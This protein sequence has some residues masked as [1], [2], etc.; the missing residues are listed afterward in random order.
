M[1]ARLLSPGERN[2]VYPVFQNT[3]PYNRV[4]I[5]DFYLPGNQ[6]VAVTVA[7]NPMPN[8]LA[9]LPGFRRLTI[10]VIFWG[11]EVFNRGADVMFPNTLVHELTH[12]W[13][14]HNHIFYQRYMVESLIVQGVA[15]M[16]HGDR[17]VAYRYDGRPLGEWS[18]YN[19]EQQANIV[20]DWYSSDTGRGGG[21]QSTSD[22]RYFYIQ[23]NIRKSA[24]RAG[25]VPSVQAAAAAGAQAGLALPPG[26]SAEVY[27]YQS[28][29]FDLG[30]LTDRKYVDGYT[31]GHT[32][33]AVIAFQRRNGLPPDGNVGRDTWNKLRQ[34]INTLRRAG[35]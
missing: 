18:S 13:Q 31:G 10:F 21:N 26:A 32:R 15:V 8:L 30:Y 14:G 22:P 34:P 24:P 3:I 2:T 25:G 29:L 33:R 11:R 35:N 27:A 16:T 6:G 17:N 4:L 1:K 12:V 7:G 23:N 19:V 9:A 20:S 28:L 5:A